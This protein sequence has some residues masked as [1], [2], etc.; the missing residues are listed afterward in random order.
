MATI[1][2]E[3]S[4]KYYKLLTKLTMMVIHQQPMSRKN[5]RNASLREEIETEKS[6]AWRDRRMYS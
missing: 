4:P 3:D 6:K 1:L 5:W 2:D